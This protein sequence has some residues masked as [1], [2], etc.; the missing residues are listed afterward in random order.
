MSVM[1]ETNPALQQFPNAGTPPKQ[2]PKFQPRF[3]RGYP[4]IISL[5]PL[6][7]APAPGPGR[8]AATSGRSGRNRG[9][10]AGKVFPVGQPGHFTRIFRFFSAHFLTEP[11]KRERITSQPHAPRNFSNPYTRKAGQRIA[12]MTPRIPPSTSVAVVR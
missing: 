9:E 11:E 4:A 12:L 5:L 1:N 10:V 8:T 7:P 3:S 2:D 6:P